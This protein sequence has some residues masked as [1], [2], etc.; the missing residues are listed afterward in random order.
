MRGLRSDGQDSLGQNPG[1]RMVFIAMIPIG[2]VLGG[3]VRRCW[4]LRT[5]SE[6]AE[7]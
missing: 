6:Q 7:L 3:S 5:A 1:V 4:G 2:R